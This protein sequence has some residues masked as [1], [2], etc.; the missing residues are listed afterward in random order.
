[1][2]R[3]CCTPMERDILATP[4]PLQQLRYRV[5]GTADIPEGSQKQVVFARLFFVTINPRNVCPFF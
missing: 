3:E 2:A 4:N 1:M 5:H